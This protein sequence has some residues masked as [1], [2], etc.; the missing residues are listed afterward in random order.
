MDVLLNKQVVSL[1]SW[2]EPNTPLELNFAIEKVDL[3]VFEKG[4]E[5]F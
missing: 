3:R 2:F 4:V 5:S 1:I